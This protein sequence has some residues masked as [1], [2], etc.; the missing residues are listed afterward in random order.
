M[1][2]QA[3]QHQSSQQEL[4]KP[5][6]A[7]HHLVLGFISWIGYALAGAGDRIR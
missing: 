3:D 6:V 4:V 5:R 2:D 1:D 7:Y